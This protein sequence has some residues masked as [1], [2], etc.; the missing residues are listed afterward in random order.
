MTI[1]HKFD[2]P[3]LNRRLYDGTALMSDILAPQPDMDIEVARKVAE[4]ITA[5]PEEHNQRAWASKSDCGTAFCFAG[6]AVAL[7]HDIAS[8]NWVSVD[9]DFSSMYPADATHAAY[10]VQNETDILTS[11]PSLAA[12]KLGLVHTY[13][14]GYKSPSIQA[15]LLFGEFNSLGDIWK[16]LNIFSDGAIEVPAEFL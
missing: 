12:E 2:N 10:S 3:V 1:T 8:F 9:F 7:D 6:H 11:I 4:H 14:F 16:L 5:H 13:E 15:N